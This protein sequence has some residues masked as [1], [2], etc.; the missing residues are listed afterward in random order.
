MADVQRWANATVRNWRWWVVL[1]LVPVGFALIATQWLFRAIQWVAGLPVR[2][3][4]ETEDG[5]RAVLH[6]SRKGRTP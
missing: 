4:D 6:W 2:A 3:I 5:I 1:P